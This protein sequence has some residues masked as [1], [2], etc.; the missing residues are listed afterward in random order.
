[1]QKIYFIFFFILLSCGKDEK[2]L[3]DIE[4]FINQGERV[5]L[6]ETDD[7]FKKSVSLKKKIIVNNYKKYKSWNQSNYNSQNY[8]YPSKV[9][10]GKSKKKL[11]NKNQK[12]IVYKNK[13]IGIDDV[14]NLTIYDEKFKRINS[15]K[16]YKRKVYKNYNLKFELIAHKEKIF[17]SDNLGNLHSFNFK[18]LKIH[19]KKKL[20]IPFRSNI[21]IYKN[22]LFLV[23][24]NSKIFSIST[25]DGKLNWSFE[26]ASKNLKNNKSYQI[27][28]YKD[29]L[30]FTNDSAEIYC[31]DLLK[32]N[33]RW[34]LVFNSPSFKTTPLIFKSSPITIDDF[35]NLYVSSN[36]GF[37]YAIDSQT[38]NIKWT[39]PVFTTN[40]IN[41]N[42]ENVFLISKNR[43]LILNRN[44]GKIVFNKKFI[45][46]KNKNILDLRDLIIGGKKFYLLTNSGVA[47]VINQNNLSRF[48][49]QNIL[50]NYDNFIIFKNAIYLKN[51]ASLIKY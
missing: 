33:V 43:F 6:I 3:V 30:Y 4:S 50:D 35:G 32:N 22:N 24:S 11:S 38:G 15:K 44:D 45:L 25:K 18:N 20:G 40:R 51:H 47:F 39:L 5:N 17:V 8:I 16:I 36:Y 23:N 13:F 21:K 2:N 9:E 42:S 34:S 49:V 41:I 14:S 37:T 27:A 19:W 31:L 26:T 29:K 46:S 28:I 12:I 10:L 1:M 7:I 48:S